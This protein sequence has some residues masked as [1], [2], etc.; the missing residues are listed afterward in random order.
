MRFSVFVVCFKMF[1][2]FW[3]TVFFSEIRNS[4]SDLF[5]RQVCCSRNKIHQIKIESPFCD[6]MLNL[7]K[8]GAISWREFWPYMDVMNLKDFVE[9]PGIFSSSQYN[10]KLNAFEIWNKVIVNCGMYLHDWILMVW[11]LNKKVC[12]DRIY[13]NS[14]WGCDTEVR[15]CIANS[16]KY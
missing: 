8:N 2:P 5:T 6:R 1:R 7:E 10:R 4:F 11:H 16:K 12:Q 15:S 13:L 9:I 14:W 3:H